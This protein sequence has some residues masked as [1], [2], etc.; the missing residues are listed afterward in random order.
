MSNK[1]IKHT[2]IALMVGC[3]VTVPICAIYFVN[4]FNN[5]NEKNRIKQDAYNNC[6]DTELVYAENVTQ[7]LDVLEYCRIKINNGFKG[8]M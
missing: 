2:I 7:K 6:R 5:I 1:Y 3:F 4:A 8:D